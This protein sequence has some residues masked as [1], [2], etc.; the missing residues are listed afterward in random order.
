MIADT[1][2]V[3]LMCIIPTQQPKQVK[4]NRFKEAFEQADK[5]FY[6]K[7][8]V[9]IEAL[10]KASY[11]AVKSAEDKTL[12]E[13]IKAINSLVIFKRGSNYEIW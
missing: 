8:K 2:V 7:Y 10:K 5:A 3:V 1:I 9:D 4:Q 6:N 12:K 11:E 13:K